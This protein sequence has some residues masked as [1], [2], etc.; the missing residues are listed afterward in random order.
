MRKI[1]LIVLF[2]LFL[3]A[4]SDTIV[5]KEK[6]N[7]LTELGLKGPVKSVIEYESKNDQRSS[8]YTV[9]TFNEKGNLTEKRRC[10]KLY[11]DSETCKIERYSYWDNGKL[12]EINKLDNQKLEIQLI[13]DQ[14]G[15][16]TEER[17]ITQNYKTGENSIQ[18]AYLYTY[19]ENGNLATKQKQ[20]EQFPSIKYICDNAGNVINEIQMEGDHIFMEVKTDYKYDKKG[21]IIEECP[22]F[23]IPKDNEPNDERTGLA[24]YKYT[25]KYDDNNLLIESDFYVNKPN[26]EDPNDRNS[27]VNWKLQPDRHTLYTYDKNGNQLQ[28]QIN[29]DQ[30]LEYRYLYDT[31]GNWILNGLKSEP[32]NYKERAIEYFVS[33]EEQNAIRA[34]QDPLVAKLIGCWELTG[35]KISDKVIDCSKKQHSLTFFDVS[36][37]GT[38]CEVKEILGDYN[39]T[40]TYAV[41]PDKKIIMCLAVANNEVDDEYTIKNIT[42]NELIISFMDYLPDKVE[43]EFVFSKK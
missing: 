15:R 21:N 42:D 9:M 8:N 2:P 5:K 26:I 18:Y 25:Y 41:S 24:E 36:A 28:M 29:N 13:H 33:E 17:H 27:N 10:T 30:P 32:G 20:G 31:N 3:G 7:D 39:Q 43:H 16:L 40:S 1:A 12:K 38:A 14:E 34:K 23:K 4:C 37:N 19:D 6:V 22:H 11:R 35:E